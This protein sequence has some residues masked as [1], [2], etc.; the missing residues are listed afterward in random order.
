MAGS[1]VG[2]RNVPDKF[3]VTETHAEAVAAI[4]EAVGY[5][6]RLVELTLEG[7]CKVSIAVGAIAYV[8]ER[9]R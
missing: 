4:A 6:T 7:G 8:I 1:N 2:L 3:A 5:P 9:R